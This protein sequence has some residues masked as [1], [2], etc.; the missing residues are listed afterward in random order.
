MCEYEEDTPQF[1]SCISRGEVSW[2]H[3]TVLTEG[4]GALLYCNPVSVGGSL[5][6]AQWG[7]SLSLPSRGAWKEREG[8]LVDL[9]PNSCRHSCSTEVYPHPSLRHAPIYVSYTSPVHLLYI[10]CTS[11]VRLLYVSY[12]SPICPSI[13]PLPCP[14]PPPLLLVICFQR[15]AYPGIWAGLKPNPVMLSL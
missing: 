10:S 11:P 1:Q 2:P 5:A 8:H 15:Y 6:H 4:P 12:T 7:S 14:P 3:H 9:W 13:S